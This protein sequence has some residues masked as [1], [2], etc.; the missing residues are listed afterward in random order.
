MVF[1]QPSI[2]RDSET[3]QR[4]TNDRYNYMRD[5]Q[6]NDRS[7]VQLL[8][9]EQRPLLNDIPRW[10][11]CRQQQRLHRHRRRPAGRHRPEAADRRLRRASTHRSSAAQ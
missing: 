11:A 10:T 4:Y 3:A 1:I 6:L 8:P 2:L 5:M 9:S 7:P